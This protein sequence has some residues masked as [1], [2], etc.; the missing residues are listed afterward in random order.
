[1]NPQTLMVSVSSMLEQSVGQGDRLPVLELEDTL[2]ALT[3]D[4]D[5]LELL[6]LELDRLTELELGR[7]EELEL[8]GEIELLDTPEMLEILLPDTDDWLEN[9]RELLE[10]RELLLK[11]EELDEISSRLNSMTEFGRRCR[12]RSRVRNALTMSFNS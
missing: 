7:L 3:D 6:R 5:R 12:F 4:I 10:L 1:M 2:L 11:L 8:L 9:N